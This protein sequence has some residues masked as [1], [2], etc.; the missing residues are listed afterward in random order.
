MALFLFTRAILNDEPIQV[1]NYGKM[2][3]DFTYIDDIIEGVYRVM[4]RIPTAD[5]EW[6]SEQ[7]DPA[8]SLAPY[9]VFNIGNNNSVELEHFIR[10]LEE[11]LGKRAQR[12]YMPLQPGDVPQTYA[13]VEDLMQAVGYKPGTPVETGVS[14]FVT[15]Y[16]SYYGV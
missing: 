7:P 6:N 4:D 2:K 3:R 13:D 1:F 11:C 10:V 14:E 8:T 12:T 16:R 15:W 5:A 9:R